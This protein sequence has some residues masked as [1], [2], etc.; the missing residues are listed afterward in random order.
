MKLL[1]LTSDNLR[2][3]P[4]V[5]ELVYHYRDVGKSIILHDHFGS[6]SDTRF[7]T[8]RISALLSEESIT[9]NT[10]FGD[11]RNII[12]ETATGIFIRQDLLMRLLET[13]DVL[14]LNALCLADQ[15]VKAIDPITVAQQLRLA[16][17]LETIHLFA[18]N[19]R[20]PMVAMPRHVA[21]VSDISSLWE[22]YEEESS[23]LNAATKLI[24]AVIGSP[25]NF[26]EPSR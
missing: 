15:Q 3:T 18:K 14:V 9:N 8:K 4:F 24:P 19:S 13:V 10:V 12:R 20:S 7:V 5:K 11:Q 1:Y 17:G 2:N 23:V 21:M 25:S 16:F 6:V 26:M 22:A